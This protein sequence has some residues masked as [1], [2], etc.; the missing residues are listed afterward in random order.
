MN[1]YLQPANSCYPLGMDF[2]SVSQAAKLLGVTRRRVYDWVEAGRIPI[3]K[4]GGHIYIDRK[5]C[6]RP[7]PIQQQ[8]KGG[9]P[10]KSNPPPGKP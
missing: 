5:D 9:R 10:R 7:E 8:F 1:S 3:Q 6:S 2:L 4:I